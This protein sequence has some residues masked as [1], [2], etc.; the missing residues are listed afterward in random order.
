MINKSIQKID[1]NG[2]GEFDN[3]ELLELV[4]ELTKRP[5]IQRL[6]ET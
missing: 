5:G 1:K 6:F 3:V 2:D 4:K